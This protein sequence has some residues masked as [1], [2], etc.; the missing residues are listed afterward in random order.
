[1]EE[2]KDYQHQLEELVNLESKKEKEFVQRLSQNDIPLELKLL[3]NEFMT[4]REQKNQLMIDNIS[5]IQKT[6]QAEMED[7]EKKYNQFNE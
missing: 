6:T 1:M 3:W 4:I 5:K 2:D 7:L